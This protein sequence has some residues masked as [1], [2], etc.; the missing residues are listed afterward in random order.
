MK[1]KIAIMILCVLMVSIGITAQSDA[2]ETIDLNGEWDAVFATWMGRLKDTIKITQ[3]GN[4]F[5][6]IRLIGNV[7]EPKGSEAI[8]GELI[9]Q[10]FSQVSTLNY[11]GEEKGKSAWT[12]AQ[13]VIIEN[14]N[15]IVIQTY[16]FRDNMV[17]VTMTRK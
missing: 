16:V 15:K 9:D 1:R 8:K 10:M 17:T 3:E 11:M 13:G 6:G 4:K 14:G 5:V 2:G 7:V 12:D